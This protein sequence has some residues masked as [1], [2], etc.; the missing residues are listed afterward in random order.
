MKVSII[1]ANRNCQKWLPKTI[2]SV[3][4]QGYPDYEH[5]IL[6]D[7]STDNSRNVLKDLAKG[8]PHIKIFHA[9]KRLRCGSSYAQL[10]DAAQGD[11]VGVLDSDDALTKNAIRIIVDLY[12]VHSDVGYIWSQHW[13]CDERLRKVRIGVSSYPKK[14][15]SLLEAGIGMKHCFSHWRTYRRS[16]VAKGSDIFKEGLKSAVDKYMAYALE[17]RGIGGFTPEILYYY[18]QRLGGLSFTGR[19]NWERMKR[20]TAARRL[21]MNIKPFPTVKLG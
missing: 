21:E 3:R 6:D 15:A 11:I 7:C 10:A 20:K 2:G 13:A 16:I 8:D 4:D 1:T 12:K 17:E 18:R 5:L 14:W 19:R 9:P